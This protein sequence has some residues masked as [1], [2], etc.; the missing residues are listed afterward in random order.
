MSSLMDINMFL[1]QAEKTNLKLSPKEEFGYFKII[2]SDK[3]EQN[4]KNLAMNKII[5][6]HILFVVSCA[7]KYASKTV[8]ISDLIQE[9]V[10]GMKTAAL[11][12]NED[13]DVK[14]MS[15]AVWYILQRI[16]KF[17]DCHSSIIYIPANQKHAANKITHELKQQNKAITEL[18]LTND[19]IMEYNMVIN[20]VN[21][22]S[23]NVPV[24][25]LESEKDM[26]D[27]LEDDSMMERI[28]EKDFAKRIKMSIKDLTNK[29][30]KVFLKFYGLCG[31]EQTKL[32]DIADEMGVKHQNLTAMKKS[33]M[34]KIRKQ[35]K[36]IFE[37]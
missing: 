26:I 29:E 23:L 33:I 2:H 5:Q 18:G 17:I 12:Y 20:A 9:G 31:H 15:Y 14:F 1:K 16:R 22:D 11:K 25:G 8:A 4:I 27:T 6:N 19:E 34:S 10:I 30:K 35:K 37:F 32:V 36:I 24:P 7:K 13:G 21:V 3:V 28:K